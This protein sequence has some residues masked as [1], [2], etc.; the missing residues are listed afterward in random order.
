[1]ITSHTTRLICRHVFVSEVPF[2]NQTL[3]KLLAQDNLYHVYE[4]DELQAQTGLSVNHSG[5]YV[6]VQLAGTD[7]LSLAEVQ[8]IGTENAE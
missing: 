8:V 5:R 7:P 6:R 1:M 2:G 3:D 4:N